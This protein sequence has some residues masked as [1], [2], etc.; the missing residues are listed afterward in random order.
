MNTSCL[1]CKIA[2][3]EIPSQ[4]VFENEK[5]IGFV[6]IHPHAKTHLI[7]IHKN[8]TANITEMVTDSES[9]TEIFKAM[10]EY[11]D[12]NEWTKSGFR[13]VTNQGPDAG[14]TVFHTHFH[15]LGGEKLGRFGH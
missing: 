5:I 2:N 11:C 12:N 1:F 13:I 8:H 10:K 15:L 3:G 7:F 4:K 14:Q 6:D 9:I